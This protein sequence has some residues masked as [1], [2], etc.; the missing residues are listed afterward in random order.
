MANKIT[1]IE[2]ARFGIEIEILEE[3]AVGVTFEEVTERHLENNK[4]T[5]SGDFVPYR[6]VANL[7]IPFLENKLITQP[8][9]LQIQRMKTQKHDDIPK[10]G[11]R[12]KG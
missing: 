2:K 7:D 8:I 4:G 6:L 9:K 10:K 1:R 3:A 11:F 5:V 12:S